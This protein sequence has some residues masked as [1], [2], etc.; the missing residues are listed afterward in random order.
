MHEILIKLNLE[1][2]PNQFCK[3]AV[4]AQIAEWVG[5]AI[6]YDETSGQFTGV[7]GKKIGWWR[8]VER[9]PGFKDTIG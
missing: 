3:S 9:R 7:N 6:R 1:D 2:Y 4:A 5:K 8:M